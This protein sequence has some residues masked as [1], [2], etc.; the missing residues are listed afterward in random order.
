M[1]CA[2]CFVPCKTILNGFSL[3]GTVVHG[4]SNTKDLGFD[5]QGI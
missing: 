2:M 4:A 5:S 3:A 1:S